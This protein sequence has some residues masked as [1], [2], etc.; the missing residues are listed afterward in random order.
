MILG[1]GREGNYHDVNDKR[2]AEDI[3]GNFPYAGSIR[4]AG[5]TG[6]AGL[7]PTPGHVTTD[8]EPVKRGAA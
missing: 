3:S 7:L 1:F 6:I 5:G 4:P 8:E 2:A